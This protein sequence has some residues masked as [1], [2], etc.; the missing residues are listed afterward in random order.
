MQTN[1]KEKTKTRQTLKAHLQAAARSKV[2]EE[3]PSGVG[4]RDVQH[5]GTCKTGEGETALHLTSCTN[6]GCKAA[7]PQ[8]ASVCSSV[9]WVSVNTHVT[10]LAEE[11]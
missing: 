2:A 9:T 3:P 11:N 4:V 6:V 7:R 10:G 1:Q 8:A 5:L